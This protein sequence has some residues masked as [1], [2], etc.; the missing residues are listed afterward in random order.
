MKDVDR[1]NREGSEAEFRDAID[2]D[3]RDTTRVEAFSDGV[4]AIAI[5]LLAFELKVPQLGDEADGR[6]LLRALGEN[7]P[8][9]MAFL[10]SFLSIL[11]MWVNHHSLFKLI[12]KSDP[13]FLF[14]NGFLMLTVSA[15]PFPTG[16]MSR[17]FMTP[18]ENVAAA[19]YAGYFVLIAV[20]YRLLWHSATTGACVLSRRLPQARIQIVNRDLSFGIFMYVV[21][22]ITAFFEAHVGFGICMA[23]MIFWT[24]KA[25]RIDSWSGELR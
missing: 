17:Y 13:S 21:A 22:C 11:I 7:W 25:Y 6:S 9:Y 10:L 20:N 18:A 14:A 8:G 3:V 16:L 23:L 24:A 1:N 19:I 4:F 15:V 12:R 2:E 5:T